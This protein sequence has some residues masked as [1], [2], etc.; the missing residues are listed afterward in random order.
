MKIY[1]NQNYLLEKHQ[2]ESLSQEEAEILDGILYSNL[3]DLT[4]LMLS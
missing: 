3:M 4:R 1:K 2:E